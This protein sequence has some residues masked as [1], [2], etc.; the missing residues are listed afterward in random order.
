MAWSPDYVTDAEL[1][2]YLGSES[3]VET[4]PLRALAITAA[5]RVIDQ[6]TSRQFGKVDEPE[7]RLFTAEWDRR[8]RA[9]VVRIDDLSTDAG[10]AMTSDG[11]TVEDFTLKRDKHGHPFVRLISDA[12]AMTDTEDAISIYGTWGWAAVPDT[13]KAATLIQ[14]HRIVIAQHSPHGVAG[15]PEL[16]NELRLLER[17]HPEVAVMIRPYVRHWGAV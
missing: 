2:T 12:S 17:V 11:T 9:Y 13:I 4:A 3:T 1:G 7:A 15:S 14:A 5:S 16:G 8:R 10:V 6:A